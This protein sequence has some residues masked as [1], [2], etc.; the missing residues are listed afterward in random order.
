MLCGRC[1]AR[2]G[3]H[4]SVR[5]ST[6]LSLDPRDAPCP[7]RDSSRPDRAPRPREAPDDACAACADDRV[8]PDGNDPATQTHSAKV[9]REDDMSEAEA[10]ESGCLELPGNRPLR[11]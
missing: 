10:D 2:P 3:V 9:S 4:R 6:R 11:P 5:K 7:C 1:A 8:S